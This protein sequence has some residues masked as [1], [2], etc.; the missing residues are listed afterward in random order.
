MVSVRLALR[1]GARD[2]V[3]EPTMSGEI[4]G[5]LG[6]TVLGARLADVARA[7]LVALGALPR[8]AFPHARILARPPL[9]A[10]IHGRVQVERLDVTAFAH[11][12]AFGRIHMSR[13]H[14]PRLHWPHAR[15]WYRAP[16]KSA[17][18]TSPRNCQRWQS[19]HHPAVFG[20]RP[21]SILVH[22]GHYRSIEPDGSSRVSS[23]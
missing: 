8:T 9:G 7:R 23:R 21:F 6:V 2:H 12:S 5:V 11:R 14:A 15:W 17:N 18:A 3:V 10:P 4:V 20:R 16:R 22:F 19:Q 13:H 1:I